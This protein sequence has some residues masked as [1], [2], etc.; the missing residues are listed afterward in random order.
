M[1]HTLLIGNGINRVTTDGPSWRNVIDEI[2]EVIEQPHAKEYFDKK[3]FTLAFDELILLA[4]RKGAK[5]IDIESLVAKKIQEI[6]PNKYHERVMNIETRHILTTN[7]DYALELAIDPHHRE[8]GY[9]H[10][11][12]YNIFRCR[13]AKGIN[14]WHLHGEAEAPRSIIL[15][16]DNYTGTVQKMRQYIKAK[17]GYHNLRSP[18]KRGKYDFDKDSK[19]YSWIDVF[20]RDDIH[21][22]GVGLDYIE[23]DLWWLVYYKAD[24]EKRGKKVGKTFYYQFTQEEL[25]PN[26]IGKLDSLKAFGVEI[27]KINAFDGFGPAWDRLLSEIEKLNTLSSS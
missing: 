19:D 6:R 17:E 20:L 12:K 5:R 2:A 11:P 23:I 10:L 1:G 13:I 22:I 26:E 21:M 8:G 14:V 3:P 27:I 25:L 9:I 16:Y 18:Y 4:E 7:Y 15:G 24:L